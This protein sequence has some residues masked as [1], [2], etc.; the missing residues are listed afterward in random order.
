MTIQTVT[1]KRFVK[2][3]GKGVTK[4]DS[5]DGVSLQ[6]AA[7]KIAELSRKMGKPVVVNIQ[8][9]IKTTKFEF[10][11]NED[12]VAITVVGASADDLRRAYKKQ[13]V[14]ELVE[15][16]IPIG[17]YTLAYD[18]GTY[19]TFRVR[20]VESGKLE[21]KTIVEHL[22]GDF[23]SNKFEAFATLH[24]HTLNVWK[25]FEKSR[26][27]SG[28]LVERAREIEAAARSNKLEEAGLL[29]A[30]KSS[31]CRRCHLPLTLDASQS[32]GYG[33]VCAGK[34]GVAYPKKA[35]KVKAEK[36]T[37][38][39]V[40]DDNF[41]IFSDTEIEDKIDRASRVRGSVSLTRKAEAF[42]TRAE[43][44]LRARRE[45]LPRCECGAIVTD[46]SSHYC[47]RCRSVDGDTSIAVYA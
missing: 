40:D 12:F 28:V 38:T 30:K 6:N 43:A 19:F 36:S 47:K 34:V 17:K 35:K 15:L 45:R 41:A 27:C 42:I 2:E 20:V 46:T 1:I 33:E 11:P 9:A 14:D 8:G 21:G 23:K 13:A 31:R 37:G 44:E 39:P 18:D 3:A 5:V 22:I 25:R 26:E 4:N 29:Y 24:T 10:R 32:A 16:L 7:D